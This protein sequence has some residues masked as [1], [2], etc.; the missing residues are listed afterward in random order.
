MANIVRITHNVD[1]GNYNDFI[2]AL[3]DILTAHDDNPRQ[4][5]CDYRNGR[6]HHVLPKQ[7]LPREPKRW[8]YIKLVLKDGAETTLAVRDDNVYLIGFMNQRGELFEF[9]FSGTIDRSKRSRPML[10]GSRFLECD[11]NYGSLLHGGARN[12]KNME[13][14]RAF[15]L[16]AV[17]QL[18]GYYQ[19]Q[20]RIVGDNTRRALAGLMVIVCEATRMR[21]LLETAGW[22]DRFSCF[23]KSKHVD[24]IWGW[25]DMSEALLRWKR[26]GNTFQFP[27]CLEDIGVGGPCK[28]LDIVE[29]LLNTPIHRDPPRWRGD[30]RRQRPAAGD[31]DARLSEQQ[32]RAAGDRG[33]PS[34][35]QRPAAGEDG[36]GS[37]QQQSPPNKRRR[38]EQQH[39]QDQPQEQQPPPPPPSDKGSG[40]S[41]HSHQQETPP[42]SPADDYVA[43]GRPLVEVFAVRAGFHFVGTIAV[44]DGMRGQVIYENEN[45]GG[46]PPIHGSSSR[47]GDDDQ[48]YAPLLLTGPYRAISA[49]GSFTIEVDICGAVMAA[50]QDQGSGDVGEL[51]WDCYDEEKVY[52]RPVRE[53]IT[54][55][56]SGRKVEVTYAVLSDAVDAELEV[57]LRLPGA[58]AEGRGAV[59][60]GR[61][62]TRSKAFHH[63]H[64]AWSVLFDSE[65]DGVSLVADGAGSIARLPLARSVV[66]MPL[67]SPLVIMA[68]LYDAP[69]SQY[70]V[71][72]VFQCQDM[73]LTLDDRMRRRSADNGGEFEVS[74]TSPDRYRPRP[75]RNDTATPR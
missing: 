16:F 61:I 55:S 45:N 24:Y 18:S 38:T 3:R 67:G 39:D 31:D 1:T 68:T 17:R 57:H 49:Y 10:R 32:R 37:G 59:V 20:G 30:Q 44:F 26:D 50:Q 65:V 58:T 72:P 63:E 64:L 12:L 75:R 51:N 74:I 11:V 7:K 14:G 25:G 47:S 70:G 35:K 40:E 5:V 48:G 21:P 73:E 36:S 66:A 15:A 6:I 53:T 46:A 22:H 52:D 43:C 41:Q 19:G 2:L 9:G 23:I 28:A 71:S 42:V 29:L 4:F 62:A 13:L 33:H 8:I 60:Y 56:S 69:P 27:K 54:T 34:E